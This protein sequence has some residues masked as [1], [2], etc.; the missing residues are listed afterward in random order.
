MLKT[1]WLSFSVESFACL[2][3]NKNEWIPAKSCENLA[4]SDGDSLPFH[5]KKEKKFEGHTLPSLH[6][7]LL[8][9]TPGSFVQTWQDNASY[10][11]SFNSVIYCFLWPTAHF[12]I[13]ILFYFDANRDLP[14]L[15]PGSFSSVR[16]MLSI[17]DNKF[18]PIPSRENMHLSFWVLISLF[19]LSLAVLDS[20]LRFFLRFRILRFL[21]LYFLEIVVAWLLCQARAFCWRSPS[22]LDS[23]CVCPRFHTDVMFYWTAAY[24][25]G[26]KR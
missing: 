26:I 16:L 12:P 21:R 17:C 13:P 22:V 2:S 24:L 23:L 19:S 20:R 8:M 9:S 14:W 10:T 11:S 4:I 7:F 1:Q 25:N 5:H 18:A 15:C 3:A 6:K